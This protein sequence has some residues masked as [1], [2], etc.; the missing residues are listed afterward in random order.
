MFATLVTLQA[1]PDDCDKLEALFADYCTYIAVE[2]PMTLLY[3]FGKSRT[4]PYGYRVM[5]IYA[6]EDAFETHKNSERFPTFRE[7]LRELLSEPPT[8]HRIDILS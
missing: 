4:E 6:D 1:N 3:R 2:E 5:E 7:R 8:G